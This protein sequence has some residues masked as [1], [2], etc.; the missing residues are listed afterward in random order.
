MKSLFVTLL[1]LLC[2]ASASLAQDA[3]KDS[4]LYNE[5]R[6]AITAG[7]NS[8]VASFEGSKPEGIV[9]LFASD[10]CM[11]SGNGKVTRG[12]PAISDRVTK[13]MAYFGTHV[14]VTVKT[15]HIWLVDLTAY[16]TGEYSYTSL[17][18][19]KET[20]DSGHYTTIWQK[21][22]DGSWKI[23]RDMSVE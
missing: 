18:D 11:F 3:A 17:Q 13:M 22:K 19:G 15:L 14:K 8:W 9:A 5:A 21:Q 20:V 10:G 16:E 23:I 2:G 6:T 12:L 4:V 1:C 7:N